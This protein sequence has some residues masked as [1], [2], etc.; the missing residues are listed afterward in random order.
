MKLIVAFIRPEK[1][2]DVLK[3]LYKTEVRGLTVTHVQGHGGETDVVE[4]YRGMTVK[5]E[6]HDKTRLDIGVSDR[7]VEPTVQAILASA[8]TGDVGDG[9]VFVL[10]LEGVVRIRTDERGDAA[11]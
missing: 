11:I 10:P 3:A 7:F 9:K 6:L 4:N 2:N 5:V 1:L 8:K